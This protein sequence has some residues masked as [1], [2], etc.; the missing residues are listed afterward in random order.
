MS[1]WR[2]VLWPDGRLNPA[3]QRTGLYQF[4]RSGETSIFTFRL[5]ETSPLFNLAALYWRDP[6]ASLRP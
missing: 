1:E 4:K 3:L 2:P 6:I 5:S